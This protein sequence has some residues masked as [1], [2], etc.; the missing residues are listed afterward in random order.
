M[1]NGVSQFS[2]R[3]QACRVKALI[4]SALFMG[5]THDSYQN[6]RFNGNLEAYSPYKGPPSP[7]VDEAWDRITNGI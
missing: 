7:A 4:S 2:G 5:V 3:S 6:V 1:R